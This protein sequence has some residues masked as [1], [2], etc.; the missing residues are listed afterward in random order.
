MPLM[1]RWPGRIEPRSISSTVVGA[2]DLYPT[3]LEA[4]D[5]ALPSNHIVDG[6]SLLPVLLQEGQL[7]REAYFT[8]F[9][10]LIP[11]VS[12]RKDN[13]KLIRRFEPH[14]K[15]PAIHELYDLKEDL[16]ETRNLAQQMPV[17]LA[18]LN[19]LVD[20][21]IQET[22]ALAP[23]PNPDYVAPNPATGL[24]P[25]MCTLSLAN[26]VLRVEAAGR[27]PF[28][29]TAQ[30]R[31][32]GPLTLRMRA[33]TDRGGRG[34]IRWKTAQQDEFPAEGQTVEFQLP[35]GAQ[36]H[37]ITVQIPI[38]GALSILRLYLPAR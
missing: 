21:F 24:V 8:W 33:R 27:T 10:H 14:V 20:E 15:Y 12:V 19:A 28:L 22:G 23:K 2:I 36:W 3:I 5:V 37:D 18:E 13:W 1:V 32:S 11:A 29:G 9:P 30:L 17:K 4:M 7:H 26:G 31:N 38:S 6:T 16:G 34:S 25:K 35:A